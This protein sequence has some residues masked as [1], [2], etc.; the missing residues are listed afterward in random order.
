MLVVSHLVGESPSLLAPPV[1][2]WK[3]LDGIRGR[4]LS[5]RTICMPM[6]VVQ[7]VQL[8][9][10]AHHPHKAKG[11]CQ[12]VALLVHSDNTVSVVQTRVS[13][14]KGCDISTNNL[15][16]CDILMF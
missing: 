13:E 4:V 15:A 10:V 8:C 12:Q 6:S 1:V 14:K 7:V 16:G 9:T 2:E 11:G 3:C 5:N